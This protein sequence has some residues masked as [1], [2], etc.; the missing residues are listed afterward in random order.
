[1]KYKNYLVF[2]AP[3]LSIM[4]SLEEPET[5][6][7]SEPAPAPDKIRFDFAVTYVPRLHSEKVVAIIEQIQ[8]RNART[9]QRLMWAMKRAAFMQEI[10]I[11]LFDL[12]ER[13]RDERLP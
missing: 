8:K 6:P 4:Q 7:I 2:F 10:G 12:A 9:K 3:S 5:R 11:N 13:Q 1:M